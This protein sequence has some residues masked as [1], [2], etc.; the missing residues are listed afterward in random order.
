MDYLEKGKTLAKDGKHEEALESLSL[1]YENDKENPDI[2][3]FIGLC[4]SSL[5][6]FEYAKYHYEVALVFDPNHEKTNLMLGALDNYSSKKPPE[7]RLIRKARAGEQRSQKKEL[8]SQPDEN[9]VPVH[10][11]TPKL[12]K[13]QNGQEEQKWEDAFPTDSLKVDD[14][15]PY[16]HRFLIIMLLLGVFGL[17]G[18][19]IYVVFF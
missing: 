16:F 5:E 11:L 8:G 17:I 14:K 3:F 4:Y 1:A 18:Y 10:D 7:D 13:E 9:T 2:H 15:I 12:I 6:E 19:F